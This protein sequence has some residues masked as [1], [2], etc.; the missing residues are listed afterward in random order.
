MW[1]GILLN[2]NWETTRCEVRVSL[3]QC[4]SVGSG[5]LEGNQC[6]INNVITLLHMEHHWWH[7]YLSQPPQVW[8]LHQSRTIQI[9]KL[10]YFLNTADWNHFTRSWGPETPE[11]TLLHSELLWI[12][13]DHVRESLWCS[14]V[15][16]Q[17]NSRR[18]EKFES[19]L[20]IFWIWEISRKS[21]DLVRI[22]IL[23]SVLI[24]SRDLD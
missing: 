11:I 4:V 8:L 10:K 6:H 19:L 24:L 5:Q 3:C 20:G 15:V 12:A 7:W 23:S 21:T 13:T 1:E 17:S 2:W 18:S 14:A 16:E 22:N 9:K